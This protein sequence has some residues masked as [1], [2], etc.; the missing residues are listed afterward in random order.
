MT[1]RTLSGDTLGQLTG[2][3]PAQ[4]PAD[5]ADPAPAVSLEQLVKARSH[6]ALQAAPEPVVA[7]LLPAVRPVAVRV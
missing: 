4:A 1:Q 5:Q 3:E 6:L 2:I 7:P